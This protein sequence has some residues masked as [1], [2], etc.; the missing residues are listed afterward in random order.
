[1]PQRRKHLQINYRPI[2]RRQKDLLQKAPRQKGLPQAPLLLHRRRKLRELGLSTELSET[3][4]EAAKAKAEAQARGEPVRATDP[5][6][7]A[8]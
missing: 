4:E 3:G 7:A 6:A 1:M 2:R 8:N 5:F